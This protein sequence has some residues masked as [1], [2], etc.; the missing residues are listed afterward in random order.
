[1]RYVELDATSRGGRQEKRLAIESVTELKSLRLSVQI[2]CENHREHSSTDEE[3]FPIPFEVVSAS[4]AMLIGATKTTE[5][6]RYIVRLVKRSHPN[7]GSALDCG[8]PR[9]W[10]APALL[11][12]HAITLLLP[13]SN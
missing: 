9:R 6:A 7:V 1:M 8:K 4:S 5:P 3:A 12:F 10:T 2:L 13:R 11:T